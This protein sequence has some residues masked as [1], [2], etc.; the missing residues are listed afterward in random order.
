MRYKYHIQNGWLFLLIPIAIL[1]SIK[2]S[3]HPW[4]Q[5]LRVLIPIVAVAAV[6]FG[7]FSRK[8]R[9]KRLGKIGVSAT[10]EILEATET[11]IYD[12][13]YNPKIRLRL[14]VMPKHMST[15][16]TQFLGY[17]SKMELHKLQ[18]GNVIW[19][20]YDPNNHKKVIIHSD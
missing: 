8:L 5:Q 12:N 15:Y 17:F 3:D 11:G 18:T 10:A 7:Y 1:I 13:R 6:L 14:K 2:F 19:V 9:S 4:N 20:K 16:E